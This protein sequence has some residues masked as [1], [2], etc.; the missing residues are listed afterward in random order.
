MPTEN[1]DFQ[2]FTEFT[3]VGLR[4]L[5]LRNRLIISYLISWSFHF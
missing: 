5:K 3:L 4:N 2:L 1:H